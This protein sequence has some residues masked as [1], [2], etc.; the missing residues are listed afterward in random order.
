VSVARALRWI[1]VAAAACP[2]VAFAHG[3]IPGA[4]P[5]YAGL[6]HPLLAPA[7]LLALLGLGLYLGRT[8]ES[9]KDGAVTAL[10]VALAVGGALSLPLGDPG[11]DRWLLAL[12]LLAAAL[13]AALRPAARALGSAFSAALAAA[14]GLAVGLGSGD[15]AFTPWNRFLAIGGS[16][17]G[18]LLLVGQLGFWIDTLGR[19]GIARGVAIGVRIVAGWLVAISLLMLVMAFVTPG[20]R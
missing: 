3:E 19:S 14:V 7:H 2:A 8:D 17:V 15:P 1:G 12:S 20:A 13:V 10:A 9:H 6:L 4:T 11:T 5:F 16:A 18:A